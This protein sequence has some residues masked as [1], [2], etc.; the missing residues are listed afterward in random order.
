MPRIEIGAGFVLAVAAALG[1]LNSIWIAVGVLA[2]GILLIVYGAYDDF[3]K[4]RFRVGHRLRDWF[5]RRDWSVQ[6]EQTPSLTFHLNL[7]S[8]S[9]GYG[10][11]VIREKRTHSDFIS[12]TGL[13]LLHPDWIETLREFTPREREILFSD[14]RVYLTGKDMSYELFKLPDGE[15]IWPPQIAVQTAIPQ[16]HTLSQHSCDITAKSVELSMIGVR[17]VIR[18]AVAS[19]VSSPGP[20]PPVL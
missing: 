19:H 2:V 20:T 6:M 9:S 16:D 4:P 15:L 14:V 5:L 10:V 12:F 8:G 13:V 1:F 3:V 18:K 7:K 11:T 17:D